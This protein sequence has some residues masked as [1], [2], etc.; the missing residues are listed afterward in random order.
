MKFDANLLLTLSQTCTVKTFGDENPDKCFYVIRQQST[1]RG[2]FS[3]V[4][5]VLCHLDFADRCGLYPVIDFENFPTVY[6]EKDTVNGTFNSWEYYFQPVTNLKLSD[7]Y[8]SKRV[9]FSDNNY[10]EGYHFCIN[11]EARLYS[12]YDKYFKCNPDILS[13]VQAFY[14]NNFTGHTILGI[15]FRGQEMRTR[16]GHWFPPSK[17]QMIAAVTQFLRSNSFS[18]IFV[19]T[20]ERS[21]L[22]FLQDKFGDL[23]IA[24]DHYRTYD[25][26]AY[27][28]YPR[29][30]HMYQLG[31]EVVIDALLL[32][33]CNGM[34]G[35]TSN[36]ATFASFANRGNYV[37]EIAI[38]NG[39]NSNNPL[40]SKYLWFIKN[41]LPESLGGYNTTSA[42]QRYCDL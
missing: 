18:K 9:I 30:N 4:A 26:N 33:R 39:P 20:E 37:S 5:A 12:V 10:P 25:V 32:S 13:Y 2:M 42:F 11:K 28:Q 34:I 21:Y 16:Q 41:M 36:V 23:V 15:H 7:V 22:E 40:I 24:N 27:H 38:N 35:C 3:L 19:V 1:G 8:K 17:R 29:E 14:D 6:N 31:R